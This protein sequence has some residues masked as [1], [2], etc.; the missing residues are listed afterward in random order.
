MIFCSLHSENSLGKGE[1][2]ATFGY[3]AHLPRAGPAPQV[4]DVSHHL[5]SENRSLPC[6]S[7]D[8]EGSSPYTANITAAALTVAFRCSPEVPGL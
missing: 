2:A 4:A 7:A 6:L 3:P 5:P 1:E 8:R